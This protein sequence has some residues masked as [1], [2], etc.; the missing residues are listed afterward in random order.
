[1]KKKEAENS[2]LKYNWTTFKWLILAGFIPPAYFQ[3]SYFV[4]YEIIKTNT[5][6]SFLFWS[7]IS[8]ASLIG[9]SIIIFQE[10]KIINRYFP[11]E[12]KPGLR[13]LI[14]LLVTNLTVLPAMA[15]LALLTYKWHCLYHMGPVTMAEHM[16]EEMTTGVVLLTIILTVVEGSYFFREW[17]TGLV[18]AEQLKKESLQAQ[19][20]SLKNQVSPHFLFN[21]LNVLSNLVH[22]DADRAEEFIDE[23]AS[24]YRYVLN[25]QDKTAVTL[26][27][28][29]HFIDSY[30]YLQKIRFQ[31]GFDVKI[32]I[33]PECYGHYVVPLSLQMLVENAIKHNIVSEE[34]PLKVEIYIENDGVFVVNKINLRKDKNKSVGMGLINLKQRY[35]LLAGI[36]PEIKEEDGNFIANIPLIKP[37][38]SSDT[39]YESECC[40]HRR[41]KIRSGKA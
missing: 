5:L 27:E 13:I 7:F 23:F 35:F 11:W 14:E 21:S 12:R 17:K 24:V 30:V 38:K 8:L 6:E 10:I 19:L 32:D 26:S 22:K 18:L 31:N 37:E 39:E 28:E 15:L 34:E 3:L 20:E 40:Y 33:D 29:L 41:R 2:Y 1:M 9:L 16:I 36:L 4:Q 25:I